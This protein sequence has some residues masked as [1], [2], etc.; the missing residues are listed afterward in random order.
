MLL[1][2]QRQHRL[3]EIK[4]VEE[5][6]QKILQ[7]ANELLESRVLDRTQKLTE[8]NQ[9]LHRDMRTARDRNQTEKNAEGID[10][11]RKTG[12]ARSDVCGN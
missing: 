7:E 5:Q 12:C 10:S 2:I 3:A 8:A 9:Q 4:R 11:C 6:T 1:L